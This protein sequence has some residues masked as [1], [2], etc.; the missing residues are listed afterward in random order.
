MATSRLH[1]VLHDLRRAARLPNE[2]GPTDG[3]LLGWFIER[4]DPAAFETLVRRHGPMVLGVCRRVLGDVHNAEDAFQASF[5]V[6]VQKAN[7][8]VPR[9]AVAN[10]LYGVAH[11]TA[12][13]ARAKAIRRQARERQVKDMPHP[14]T[15]AEAAWE[16][17][18]PV[19]DEELGRLPDKYRL[20]VILCHLESRSRKEVARQLKLP[21][22]TLSSRLATARKLLA[23]RLTRRGLVFSAGA[24][25]TALSERTATAAVPAS[26]LGSTLKVAAD[27]ATGQAWADVVSAD[28]AALVEGVRK[29]MF[30]SKL[31]VAGLLLLAASL[32]VTGAGLGL[33]TALRAKGS[34]GQQKND[35]NLLAAAPDQPQ[36]RAQEPGRA[37]RYGDPLPEAAL[38]RLGTV[39]FRHGSGG[40]AVLAFSSDGRTLVSASANGLVRVWDQATG[41]ELRHFVV[42]VASP[43]NWVAL[44]PDGRT[45]AAVDVPG[46]G[47]GHEI[48]LWDVT[49]GKPLR[50]LQG[51]TDIVRGLA[52]S[53]D[54]KTLVS[55][56]GN[57]DKT[58]RVWDVATGREVHRFEGDLLGYRSPVALSRDGKFLAWGGTDRAVHVWDLEQGKEIRKVE[59]CRSA[60]FSPDGKAI[61]LAGDGTIVRMWNLATGKELHQLPGHTGGVRALTFSTD[62]TLLATTCSDGIR[63]WQTTTGKE[64]NR[65]EGGRGGGPLVFSPDG[66]VLAAGSEGT[67]HRWDVGTGRELG[68]HGGHPGDVLSVAWSHDGQ[69]LLTAGDTI[70]VWDPRTGKER[71]PLQTRLRGVSAVALAPDGQTLAAG[72]VDGIVLYDLKA[73]KE[74]RQ[75]S[76]ESRFTLH[77]ALSPD[78]KVLVSDGNDAL[79]VWDMAT[80]THLRQFGKPSHTLGSFSFSPDGKLLALAAG[81]TVGLWDVSRGQEVHQLAAASACSVAFSPDGKVLACGGQDGMVHV[82]DSLTRKPLLEFRGHRYGPCFVAFS[83]DSRTLVLGTWDRAAVSVL[84]V[85]TGQE[86]CKFSGHRAGVLCAAISP[87][88]GRVASGSADTTVLVWDATGSGGR[89]A[90]GKLRPEELD[91]AWADLAGSDASKAYQ[92]MGRLIAAPEQAVPL[93]R[94]RLEGAEGLRASRALEALERIGSPAARLLL[95][96]LAERVPGGRLSEEARAAARRLSRRAGSDR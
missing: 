8:V 85:A 35:S 75:L 54:G 24:L 74:V 96:T 28:V 78:G 39:R 36:P 6:L 63:L 47:A 77:L 73:R 56:S 21:E 82:W 17:L 13:G 42:E 2:A 92:A 43:I 80:G 69:A 19:L 33:H 49:A 59:G 41:K 48:H 20:P 58:I 50:V 62:G 3:Q 12:L 4:R 65:L 90:A 89:R 11:R 38:A 14:L 46:P 45:F 66:K 86:R 70:R 30:V 25:S 55:G 79:H 18:K 34:E 57:K 44:S 29:A 15:K 1:R 32:A 22:G 52:F 9:E 10:W 7:T 67:V 40:V 64:L 83:P 95:E 88:G 61:A 60:A 72:G 68:A 94:E 53:A 84:E 76:A 87:D 91:A 27:I 23:R 81:D 31:K 71:L 26:L 16:E 5:L 51:H 37:D 93:L